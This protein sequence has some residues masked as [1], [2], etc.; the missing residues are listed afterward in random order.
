MLAKGNNVMA[1]NN[2]RDIKKEIYGLY[3]GDVAKLIA[4]VEVYNH[5]LP[6]HIGGLI[7]SVFRMISSSETKNDEE[8]YYIYDSALK[9]EYFLINILYLIIIQLY[10]KQ[11]KVYKKTFEKFNF[12]PIEIRED[13]KT[14]YGLDSNILK[15][16]II[17]GQKKVSKNYSLG[18]KEFKNMY[19][20]NTL[21]TLFYT[22]K[23]PISR[24]FSLDKNIG[25]KKSA[26]IAELKDSYKLSENIIQLCEKYYSNVIDNGYN[27]SLG[28]RII[29]KIPEAISFIL[30][31]ITAYTLL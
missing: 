2:L 18:K 10:M 3:V 30:A 24:Y 22:E 23:L 15:T 12:E 17:E 14:R 29:C 4:I 16:I 27:A 26:C 31:L 8:C 1:I 5:N 6:R 20:L 25:L 21:Q 7:E 13:D 11:I 19:E 28:V 9:Y